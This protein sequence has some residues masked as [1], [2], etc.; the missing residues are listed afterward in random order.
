MLATDEALTAIIGTA[1]SLVCLRLTISAPTVS[2]AALAPI[3]ILVNL[4]RL[5]FFYDWDDDLEPGVASVES[6]VPH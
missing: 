2:T 6:P 3:D 4:R 1:S 5:D